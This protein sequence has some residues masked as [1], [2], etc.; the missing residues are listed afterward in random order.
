[1]ALTVASAGRTYRM[2][3]DYLVGADGGRSTVRKSAGID[4][5]GHT[6]PIVSRIAHV[7]LPEELLV[8]GRGYQIPGIGLLPFGPTGL[9]TAA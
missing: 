5:P 6:S 3:A 7:Y 8:P 4:F 1:M 2:D 9:T